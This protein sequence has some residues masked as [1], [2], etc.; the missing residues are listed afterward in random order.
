MEPSHHLIALNGKVGGNF[1]CDAFELEQ[2]EWNLQGLL[3]IL[4]EGSSKSQ[5]LILKFL[6]PEVL[7]VEI[8]KDPAGMIM[9]LKEVWNDESFKEIRSKLVWPKGYEEE[10][11]LVGDLDDVGF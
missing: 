8:Q 9:K 2:G 6:S 10:A 5:E 1:N 7:N 4:K 11:G 3:K